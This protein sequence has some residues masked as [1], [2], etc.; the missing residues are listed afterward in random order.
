MKQPY[1]KVR[2]DEWSYAVLNAKFEEILEVEGE[3]QTRLNEAPE[4]TLDS[5][6][7]SLSIYKA[8]QTKQNKITNS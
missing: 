7:L 3:D 1:D 5:I 2:N 8:N 4:R 6:L